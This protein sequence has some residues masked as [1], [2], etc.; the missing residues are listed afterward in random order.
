[1]LE[2]KKY[3]F[4]EL[5]KLLGTNNTQSTNRKLQNWGII[6]SREGNGQK[7]IYTLMK[8]ENPF[9]VFCLSELGFAPQ[10]DFIKFRNFMYYFL[11]DDDFMNLPN[12]IKANRMSE[13]G[14]I[15]SRQ[16]V[17]HY[18][19]KLQHL[20]YIEWSN[21]ECRYYIIN[22]YEEMTYAEEI[23]REK[24]CEGWRIYWNV[25]EEEGYIV[26]YA[27]M[28]DHLGGHPYKQPVIHQNA[29]Y[30]K[31]FEMLNQLILDSFETE[32]KEIIEKK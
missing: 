7:S 12:S 1:M 27:K 10:T 13:N 2:L 26:A 18:L 21:G 22:K 9:K 29:F 3:S 5:S 30:A 31:Q 6:Y 11:A 28:R 32:Q 23:D 15:I 14:Y 8:F 19:E 4:A 17:V 20:K 16:T 24:Y 25:R